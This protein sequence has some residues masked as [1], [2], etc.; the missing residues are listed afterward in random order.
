M[1]VDY[2]YSIL[3]VYNTLVVYTHVL[4]FRVSCP[5]HTMSAEG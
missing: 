1:L 4:M 3:T 5:L 2:I